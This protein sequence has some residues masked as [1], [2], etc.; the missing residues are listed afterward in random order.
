MLSGEA[1]FQLLQQ[2]LGLL[3]VF[4]SLIYVNAYE[5]SYEYEF[6]KYEYEKEF[7]LHFKTYCSF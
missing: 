2:I 4:S 3:C 7:H 5:F 1:V 6:P